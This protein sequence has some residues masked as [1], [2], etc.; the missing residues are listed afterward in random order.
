MQ[1]SVNADQCH[2]MVYKR[3]A[4]LI[5]LIDV[6]REEQSL[7]L[8]RAGIDESE[9]DTKFTLCNHHYQVYGAHYECLQRLCCDPWKKH[10]KKVLCN[11]RP[12]DVKAAD[13]L[14]LHGMNVLPGQKLCIT[15]RKRLSQ[16]GPLDTAGDLGPGTDSEG[17]AHEE[18]EAALNTSF[19]ALGGTPMKRKVTSP[20]T[21]SEKR[22][23]YGRTKMKKVRKQ[24]SQQMGS[25]LDV[26]PQELTP[27]TESHECNKCEDLQCLV[28]EL[29]AKIAISS[30][31]K[32]LQLLTLTPQS[33][34]I[35]QTKEWFGVS[36]HLVKKARALKASSGILTEPMAK[37][38]VGL[39]TS[40][41]DAVRE[42]FEN[43][44]I[45]RLCPGKKDF[46]SIKVAGKGDINKRD[47][48]LVT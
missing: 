41:V 24:L 21:L 34:T 8:R 13:K 36:S 12:L 14:G 7:L 15:C 43:D 28:E 48:F 35:N 26:N 19:L 4:S 38:G 27:N 6:P 40:T 3:T 32:Q 20:E 37:K 46:V 33:W 44:D 23:Q 17:P 16:L 47:L 31:Q 22:L 29:K 1:H 2:Q 39:P 25:C 10:K 42:F 9:V 45:S 18:L 11:L 5:S 30:R